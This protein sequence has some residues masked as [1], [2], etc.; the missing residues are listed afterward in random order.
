MKKAFYREQY[1]I[2]TKQVEALEAKLAAEKG[3]K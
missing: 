3:K 2:L 1:G